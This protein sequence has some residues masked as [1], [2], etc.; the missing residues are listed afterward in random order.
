MQDIAANS[1]NSEIAEKAEECLATYFEI[2]GDS[3]KFAYMQEIL[4][5]DPDFQ[6][7]IEDAFEEHRNQSSD[8][9][10]VTYNGSAPPQPSSSSSYQGTK[11]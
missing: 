4:E 7:H 3:D 6:R 9:T 1:G 5:A 10:S 2:E 11:S 8:Q